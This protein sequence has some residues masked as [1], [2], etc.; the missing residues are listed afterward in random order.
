MDGIMLR[1][2]MLSCAIFVGIVQDGEECGGRNM[3]SVPVMLLVHDCM[4]REGNEKGRKTRGGKV[5]VVDLLG[6]DLCSMYGWLAGSGDINLYLYG[7]SV[8]RAL[9]DL[10]WCCVVLCCDTSW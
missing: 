6:T 9:Y 7:V 1:R 5:S 4:G 3:D 8:W 10:C 2:A